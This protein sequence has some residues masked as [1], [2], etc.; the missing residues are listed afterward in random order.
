M[1]KHKGLWIAVTALSACVIAFTLFL[2][3]YF[4]PYDDPNRQAGHHYPGDHI[5]LGL[6]ITVDGEQIDMG[7]AKIT[8]DLEG[9]T[10]TVSHQG[11]VV[12]TRG[13]DYGMYTFTVT[14]P[15]GTIAGEDKDLTANIDYMNANNWYIVAI[16]CDISLARSGEGYAGTAAVWTSYNDG[17]AES[18]TKDFSSHGG[19]LFKLNFGL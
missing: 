4:Y 19:E 10:Q 3:Y 8:C 9:K 5:T 13:G 14:L 16:G 2:L 7:K 12:T 1:P 15:G 6:H 18:F 11:S 17:R